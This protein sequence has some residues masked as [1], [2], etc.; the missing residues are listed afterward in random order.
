MAK[1]RVISKILQRFWE[2]HEER[3]MG[4]FL[5]VK[6]LREGRDEGLL[7][8]AFGDFDDFEVRW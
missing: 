4:G 2:R 3:E 6:G 8:R 5:G 1:E 7:I